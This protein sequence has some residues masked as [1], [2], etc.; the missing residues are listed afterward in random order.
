ME[1]YVPFLVKSNLFHDEVRCRLV[2]NMLTKMITVFKFNKFCSAK[3]KNFVHRRLLLL[4][5]VAM[6]GAIVVPIM[7]RFQS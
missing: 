1:D 4:E 3:V 5:E 6:V 7:A 2:E